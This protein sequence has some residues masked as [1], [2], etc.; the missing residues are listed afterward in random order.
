M[1]TDWQDLPE[2]RGLGVHLLRARLERGYSQGRLA[3]EC[4]LSQAQV[5]LFE[6][7]RRLPSLDQFVRLARALGVPLQCLLTGTSRPGVE[8]KDLAVELRLLGAVDLWVLDVG[9]PGAARRAEEVIALAASGHSPDARVVETLP[10]L[11]SW[12]AIHPAVLRG[13]GIATKTTNRLAWL[14]DVALTIDQ[15][16][17]FPGGCRREPLERF[18]KVVKLPPAGNAWDDLG[19][20]GEI[21]PASPVWRRWKVSYG[22]TAEDFERRA[23]ELVAY[24]EALKGQPGP[25][26]VRTRATG[27]PST[28]NTVDP[29]AVAPPKGRKA[30]SDGR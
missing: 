11:L 8:L 22:A 12:N 2:L 19:R 15:K 20:P 16:R 28:G 30:G 17:G 26:G 18:L 21:P 27:R 23:R 25:G 9:V 14:A 7:G 24:R 6:A 29:E 5:S 4:K 1:D 3:R 13:H 10:A